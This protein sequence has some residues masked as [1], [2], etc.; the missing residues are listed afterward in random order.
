[1]KPPNSYKDVQKL[2]R[3]LAALNRFISRSGER[4]LPFFKNLRHMPKET[5][6]WDE[7]CKEAFEGLKSKKIESLFW[8]TSNTCG[9]KST[10]KAVA[11]Q[12]RL[13]RAIDYLDYRVER[14]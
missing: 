11:M 10:V 2:T 5:F 4:N 14:V 6:V 13:V 8:V 1:M 3:C 12:S 9:D 7:E